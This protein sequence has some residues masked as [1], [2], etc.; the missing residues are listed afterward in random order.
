MLDFF[1]FGFDQNVAEHRKGSTPLKVP[2]PLKL[3]LSA[4]A[5]FFMAECVDR[6]RTRETPVHPFEPSYIFYDV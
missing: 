6:V 3:T 1:T 5:P 4:F 2:M